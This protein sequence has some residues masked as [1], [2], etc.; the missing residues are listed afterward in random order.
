MI[1][2]NISANDRGG[3]T[4]AGVDAARLAQKYQTPL[5]L[6]DEDRIRQNMR[7]FRSA[8]EQA[9]GE[10]AGVAYACKAFCI[11]AMF[12]ILME[13]GLFADVVSGGE[14]YTALQAGFPAA[15]IFFHGNNKQAW[16]LELALDAGVGMFIVDNARELADLNA[17]AAARGMRA[18]AMLRITP[19]IDPDTFRAVNT[20]SID[21][22][23]GVP[24]E[25]GQAMDFVKAARAMPNLTLVGL[26]SHIGSQV[27]GLA[28][29]AL[30]IDKMLDFIREVKDQ[31]G[32]VPELLN[33][34]GG[35]PARYVKRDPAVDLPGRVAA[36]GVHLKNAC[37]AR[38]L[39]LPRVMIEP[40][41][42]IVADAGM[43]LYRA[44]TIKPIDGHKTYVV[45]DGGMTDNPRYAL[46]GAAY[47]VYNASRMRETSRDRYTIAG[48][49]CETGDILQEDVELPRV[50]TGDLIAV[51]VTGAYND[52]MSSN[53]NRVTRPPIVM[54]KGGEDRLVKRRETLD[55]LIRNDL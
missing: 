18:P 31:T 5:Y 17:L 46:Y 44:G 21:C 22:Q 23:F 37:L 15:R 10:T 14:L 35:F 40:G 53:Y 16:E 28:P 51:A 45:V 34:G 50:Q 39:D 6:M 26:H 20:G 13:E 47:T 11:K 25:T 12:P 55:D 30:A 32:Y 48:R 33:L 2:E 36:I 24:I 1:H 8:A 9:F 41:R 54:L 19:G 42:S 4:F 43:T 3:L 52:A 27:F 29:F 7:M 38:G 49:C